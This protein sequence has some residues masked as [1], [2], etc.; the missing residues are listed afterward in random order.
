MQHTSERHAPKQHVSNQQQGSKAAHP[1][2][3]LSTKGTYSS[4]VDADTWPAMLYRFSAG[5]SRL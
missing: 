2:S 4:T 5:S 1:N 3:T